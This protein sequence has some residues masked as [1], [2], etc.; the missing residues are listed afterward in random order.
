MFTPRRTAILI[1]IVSLFLSSVLTE[2][3]LTPDASEQQRAF[4]DALG[5]SVTTPAGLV[6]LLYVADEFEFYEYFEQRPGV[7]I[8]GDFVLT[9]LGAAVASLF[10]TAVLLEFVSR[11]FLLTTTTGLAG[12]FGATGIFFFRTWSYLNPEWTGDP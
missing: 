11:G 10:A 4:V 12:F 5:F 7:A 9:V 8:A 2:G 6:V 3:L 1:A